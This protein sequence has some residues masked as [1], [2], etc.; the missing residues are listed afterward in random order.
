MA[1][2]F[3]ATNVTDK[4]IIPDKS[5]SR[6]VQP[7]IRV[8]QFGD[9]Y[10][11]RLAD[12]INN[13]GETFTLNFMNRDK[14]EADDIIAFFDTKAGV[15]NFDFT[16]PDTN[17]TTTATAKVNG[18]ISTA[19]TAVVLDAATTNLDISVGATVTGSG[20]STD[21]VVKVAAISGINLTLDTAQTMSDNTDL[22]F[23]NPNERTIKVVCDTWNLTYSSGDFYTISCTFRRVFEP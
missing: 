14:T 13:L 8:A 5:L 10:Q 1:I 17:S 16:I 11:Q 23:T 15:S 19:S 12:G 6:A 18:A 22:T 7:R 20:I 21:P 4:K 3:T 2:G 9:G